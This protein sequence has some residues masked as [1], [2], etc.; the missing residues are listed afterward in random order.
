MAL[1]DPC[2]RGFGPGSAAL[3]T[4]T[5]KWT[6]ARQDSTD[7]R[8]GPSALGSAVGL[9]SP[10]SIGAVE[11]AYGGG[12]GGSLEA[13]AEARLAGLLHW[14]AVVATRTVDDFKAAT[15]SAQS[16]SRTA[17]VSGHRA[18]RSSEA[19]RSRALAMAAKIAHAAPAEKSTDKKRKA[20]AELALNDDAD[21]DSNIDDIL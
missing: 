21:D 16:G 20:E 1:Y 11:E 9:A 6:G 13:K 2:F 7:K 5:D 3:L 12:G 15:K 18:G 19:A 8:S 14:K 17:H 10:V 4:L